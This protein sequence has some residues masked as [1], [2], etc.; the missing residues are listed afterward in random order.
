VV[1]KSVALSPRA[2]WAVASRALAA[3]LGGYLVAALSTAAGAVWL[4][5][6]RSESTLTAMMLSFAVYVG[7]VVWVFA[8]RTASRAWLG[9]A[10][11][12]AVMGAMISGPWWAR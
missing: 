10:V 8:A 4:P 6:S 3:I 2:R 9:L 5:G 11:P 7:A 12:A 1:K